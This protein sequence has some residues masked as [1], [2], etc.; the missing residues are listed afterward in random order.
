MT[1]NMSA[2]NIDSPKLL[3]D[4]FRSVAGVILED[5]YCN[6]NAVWVSFFHSYNKRWVTTTYILTHILFCLVSLYFY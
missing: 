5:S 2:L 4:I 3:D 6:P 1:I